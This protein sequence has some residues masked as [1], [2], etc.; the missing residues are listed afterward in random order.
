MGRTLRTIDAHV[1]GQL[2]RLVIDGV[3]TPAGSS[4]RRRQ[5]WMRDH[6]DALLAALVR[7]PRGHEGVTAG[8]FTVT[9]APGAHAG[10]LFRHGGG[11]ADVCG[12]G[13]IGAVTIGIA[14][15]LLF[16]RDAEA[17]G[18]RAV[19]L[20]TAAGLVVARARMAAAGGVASVA[21]TLPPAFVVHAAVVCQG[22]GRPVRA[23][24]AW[25]GGAYAIVD[26][27]SAGLVLDVSGVAGI[28]HAGRLI[29][30]GLAG[31]PVLAHPTDGARP[32]VEAVVF[33]GPP[34]REDAHLT[35]ATV[36]PDGAVDRSPGGGATAAVLAVLDAMGL[37][38]DDTPFVHESL[39]GSRF[40]AR[41]A[42]R[43]EVGGRPAIVPEIE[44]SAWITGEHTFHV[45]DADPFP[46]GF[47]L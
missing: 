42:G 40:T 29:A 23:D 37:V 47:R 35:S 4:V 43:L 45:D 17:R 3:P 8:C 5:D 46:E 12:H 7:E 15:G 16:D 18:S 10:V 30:E 34:G 41:V 13:L 19:T 6:A 20:D 33:T 9:D 2:L 22:P 1:G 27:E 44:G 11:Y 26:A 25:C 21:V 38:L 36:Y 31:S 39:I 14:H 28:R 32:A 24:V